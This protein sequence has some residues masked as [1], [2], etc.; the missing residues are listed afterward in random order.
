MSSKEETKEGELLQHQ[1]R[2]ERLPISKRPAKVNQDVT[3]S[4]ILS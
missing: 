1:R 4:N 2:I 3:T